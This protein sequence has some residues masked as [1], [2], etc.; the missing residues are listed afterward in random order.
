MAEG[1][2]GERG[3]SK[4]GRNNK[5]NENFPA[6]LGIEGGTEKKGKKRITSKSLKSITQAEFLNE[7][8][9]WKWIG[10][11]RVISR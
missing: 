8:S 4:S 3:L 7:I 6:A 5:L 2:W 11:R 1:A 9:P 10:S